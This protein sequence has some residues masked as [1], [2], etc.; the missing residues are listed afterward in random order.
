MTALLEVRS[1]SLLPADASERRSTE[2]ANVQRPDQQIPPNIMSLARAF[3]T[4]RNNLKEEM[5][6][7]HLGRSSS[8]RSAKSIKRL[9]IS[10]P[11]A[12]VLT[13]NPLSYEAPD[14]AG[15]TRIH[16]R[17]FTSSSKNSED[18]DAPSLSFDGDSGTDASSIGES[19][20]ITPEPEP[21][22]LSCYF[23][24]AKSTPHI[25]ES[26]DAPSIP[27]RVPSHSKKAH[28]RVH[29]KRSVQRILSP[30]ISRRGSAEIFSGYASPSAE[31]F[32]ENPFGSE[33][34]QL[35]EVAEEISNAVRSA[36]ADDDAN[37]M[38]TRS[39]AHFSASEY[40]SEIHDLIYGYLA[41][42]AIW[43]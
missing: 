6:N 22:H 19:S 7:F 13:T 43:I 39:L 5:A 38:A 16:T 12:L 32:K 34:A 9:Q 36:E 21:N 18:S 20:P 26:F 33:L 31:T 24:A 41:E 28:E 11:V 40:M 8:Q 17:N 23:K 10:S 14:I 27:E 2:V 35:E 30:P 25:R 37:C 1:R 3:T 42:D 15:T 4:K 29:R